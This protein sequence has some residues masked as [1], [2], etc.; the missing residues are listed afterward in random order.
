MPQSVSSAR[1]RPTHKRDEDRSRNH[2]AGRPGVAGH[3][4][5][6]LQLCPEK[7]RR[8]YGVRLLLP[9]TD[10]RV[11]GIL[12]LF[13]KHQL[14]RH[15]GGSLEPNSFELCRHRKYEAPD[16]DEVKYLQL[17]HT[18]LISQDQEKDFSGLLQ[19]PKA[20]F[21]MPFEMGCVLFQATVVHSSFKDRLLE[22]GMKGMEFKPVVATSK[23]SSEIEQNYW[24]L[25]SSVRLPPHACPEK[26]VCSILSFSG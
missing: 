19:L 4:T 24:E 5:S 14:Q 1:Q 26:L 18:R 8:P 6:F 17:Y 22:S 25:T 13:E 12:A 20:K 21:R 2:F 23:G 9:E 10:S 16:L 7:L 15:E 3:L 11:T